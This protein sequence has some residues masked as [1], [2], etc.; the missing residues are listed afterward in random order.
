M[1]GEFYVRAI[2]SKSKTL[3][4]FFQFSK[5]LRR[6]KVVS[7]QICQQKRDPY[8]RGTAPTNRSGEY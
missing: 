2:V 6:T 1:G 3:R 5:R 7:H 8:S 4:V